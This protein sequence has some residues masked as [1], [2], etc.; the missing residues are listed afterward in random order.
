MDLTQRIYFKVSEMQVRKKL[1]QRS[2]ERLDDST[3]K[4]WFEDVV[5]IYK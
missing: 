1:I 5:V 3:R 2:Y 4:C